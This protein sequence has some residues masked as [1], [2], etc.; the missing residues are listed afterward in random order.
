[1]NID[2]K[3]IKEAI[4]QLESLRLHNAEMRELARSNSPCIVLNDDSKALDIAIEVLKSELQ[5][6][7]E[8]VE[9]VKVKRSYK[10]FV[11]NDQDID[12]YK[13]FAQR[14]VLEMLKTDLFVKD[15]VKITYL[16]R[17]KD[18]KEIEVIAE[19]DVVKREV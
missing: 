10:Q 7:R 18:F 3:D 11:C 1:M 14:V 8:N 16:E 13:K 15:L 9:V 12:E 19:L 4:N 5:I 17:D 2:K 6:T